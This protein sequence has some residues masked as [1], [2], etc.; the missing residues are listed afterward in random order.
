MLQ[1][2]KNED[3]EFGIRG[4][5]I[6]DDVQMGDNIVVPS[7]D[8]NDP[9]WIMLFTKC[10]HVLQKNMLDGWNNQYET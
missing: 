6:V 5:W 7:N 10:V 4:E 9:F 1:Q 8:S 2:T 3:I